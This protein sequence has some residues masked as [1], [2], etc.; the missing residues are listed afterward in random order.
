MS[1]VTG[2]GTT[3]NLPNYHGELFAV[4]PADTPLLSSIGGLTGGKKATSWSFEWQ[5]FDLRD[6]AI[7]V[8]LE[9]AS[10]PTAEERARSN[11]EN[12]TEIHQEKVDVSYSKQAAIGQYAT[13]SSAPYQS[14]DGLPNGIV[15]ELD[16]QTEQALKSI[17]RDVN[18][19]FINGK[20]NKPSSNAAYR[21]TKGLIQAIS[22]NSVQKATA[23][24]TGLSSATDTITET[25]TARSN[26][27]KIVFTSTG[28]ATNI[29]AG[30]VYYV[31]NKSTNAFKVA[32]TS[33]GTALTLG[34]STSDLDYIVP[35][36]TTL[37]TTHVDDI[38]QMA[39]DNGGLSEQFT[40]T[41]LCNSVQKRAITTAWANA[42]QK[43]DPLVG[44]RNVGGVNVTTLETD[45]GVLNVM[46]DRSIPQDAIIIASLEQLAPVFTEIPDKGVFFVEELAK[47]GASDSRQL[48]GEI[49]LQ[50]GNEK[51]H[52]IVRGLAV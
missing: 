28:D 51:A 6:P 15:S 20:V 26:G 42:Y 39:Y 2:I 16:W 8:R 5:T 7:R 27:D 22:T 40:A 37:A 11:V 12:V 24:V 10:A 38:A 23:T 45:F 14:N 44:T 35:W 3:F 41:L 25:S 52:A 13:A 48:Y 31:V 30:R 32:T 34:T 43:V 21:K 18:F 17:A 46:L 36:T 29:V 47:T 49:G 9:G 33:G 50:F 19:S 1:T 4:T